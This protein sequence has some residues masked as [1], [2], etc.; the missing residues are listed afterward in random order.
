MM[1]SERYAS[2]G[3]RL[4]IIS[5]TGTSSESKG[6]GGPTGC[7]EGASVAWLAMRTP[8]IRLAN[9]LTA[10]DAM[11]GWLTTC[12]RRRLRGRSIFHLALDEWALLVPP[13]ASPLVRGQLP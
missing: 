10:G 13:S 5:T 4:T 2:G 3:R 1:L 6:G 9:S 7:G 8:C 11:V 12:S